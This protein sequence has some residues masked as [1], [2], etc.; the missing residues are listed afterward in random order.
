MF[1]L[2]V[3]LVELVAFTILAFWDQPGYRLSLLPSKRVCSKCSPAQ[4]N[5]ATSNQSQPITTAKGTAL[6][7]YPRRRAVAS[8]FSG[9]LRGMNV[10]ENVA[11]VNRMTAGTDVF[12]CTDKKYQAELSKFN[13]LVGVRFKEDN[14]TWLDE[15][16]LTKETQWWRL[17]HCWQMV[18]E[19]E[20]EHG[21]R[22]DF[23]MKL[24]TDC[25]KR[26]GCAEALQTYDE[27]LKAHGRPSLDR[28]A[29]SNSDMMF[30]GT[31][32]SFS[33]VATL[34]FQNRT[35][36]LRQESP[37]LA[38]RFQAGEPHHWFRQ[39]G[40]LDCFPTGSCQYQQVLQRASNQ[41]IPSRTHQLCRR[42]PSNRKEVGRHYGHR[43]GDSFGRYTVSIRASI[44]VGPLPRGL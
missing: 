6:P 31:R 8:I 38:F 12:V 42:F 30:G 21:M 14:E 15:V 27:V 9:L 7:R 19:Y 33:R 40:L 3:F 34:F 5:T 17:Q 18:M 39:Q 22:Y 29:F 2:L 24:R 1:T 41:T 16:N 36:L 37:L 13:N 25:H 35:R 20:T 28:M 23:Y 32:P 10:E 26:G 11:Q 4:N 43:N 44:F